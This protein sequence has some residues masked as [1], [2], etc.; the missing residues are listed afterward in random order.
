MANAV[1][2]A[3]QEYGVSDLVVGLCCDTTASNTGEYNGA[4]VLIEHL[5]EKDLL[6]LP[7][8]HHHIFEI[9]LRAVFDSKFTNVS[10]PN[11]P[12]FARFK[13]EWDGLDL[14]Q[15]KSGIA[16]PLIGK[17]LENDIQDIHE[18]I[19]Q[20]LTLNHDR[21]DYLELLELSLLFIGII[22]DNIT[23]H[24][25]GAMHQARWM[26]K[27]I[28]SLK[29]FLLRSTFKLKS[30]E[31]KSLAMICVFIV[32]IYLRIWFVA[33]SSIKAPNCDFQLIKSIYNFQAIDKKICESALGKILNHLWYL[34]PENCLLALFD[35]DV[36]TETKQK[37]V[38][39]VIELSQNADKPDSLDSNDKQVLRKAVVSRADIP[40][41]FDEGL[42]Q[43]INATSI[44]FFHKL[45]LNTS[46]LTE[47]C[48][49]WLEDSNYQECLSAV[50]NLSVVNDV[51]ERGVK[52]M[53]EYNDLFTK[54]EEQ[55]QFLIQILDDYRSK[56]I[57]TTKES[58]LK[59]W[60]DEN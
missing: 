30:T 48:E 20:Q 53:Q 43:F 4:A 46:W 39:K 24:T 37:M 6:I 59:D 18:F 29:I 34:N 3:L 55:K 13:K 14:T 9:V 35:D 44:N 58:L 33:T 1:S 16:D 27:A 52:L 45:G 54:D 25:P 19:K 11:V 36:D 40:K 31:E 57:K 26:A 12:I 7:C 10:G 41:L 56:G 32:K 51:A 50:T 17:L 5:L 28:Y 15:L 8:R 47:N 23:F 21:K 38:K 49:N 22:P 42:E 60:N 2:D